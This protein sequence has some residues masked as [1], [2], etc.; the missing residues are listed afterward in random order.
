MKVA[1]LNPSVNTS[2]SG[3]VTELLEKATTFEEGNDFHGAIAAYIALLKKQP[4]NEKAY[5]R[6]MI[7]YRKQKEYLKE[8][9]V[10]EEAISKFSRDV[11]NGKKD[12]TATKKKPAGKIE[13]L[14]LSLGKLTGLM[15]RKGKSLYDPEPI[16]TWKKR[17][18]LVNKRLKP[19]KK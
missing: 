10:I 19:K 15:D 4:L 2:M 7:L 14:S 8:A 16:A 17:L 13:Q 5:T 12:K 18:V 3:S 6:L 1:H 9:A 11:T